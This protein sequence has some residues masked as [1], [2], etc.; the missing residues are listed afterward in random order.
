MALHVDSR[1]SRTSSRSCV[2]L[3]LLCGLFA[4]V[5]VSTALYLV[6]GMRRRR[7]KR[8]D[9]AVV[10]IVVPV[11][12]EEQTISEMLDSLLEIDYPHELLEIII[13]N[14]QSVDRTREIAKTYVGRFHCNYRVLDVDESDGPTSLAKTR[15]LMKGL[16]QAQGEFILMTDADCVIPRNW[17]RGVVSQ[18]TEDV[19]MVC[20]ITVPNLESHTRFPFTWFETLDWLLLMGVCSGFAGRDRA[21]A[22][23]GNNYAVRASTYRELG[24][25]R[26]LSF[27]HIDDIALMLAV[28][29]I[30]KQRVV[31]PAENAML[32][33]TRPL[34]SL[35]DMISQRRR[36]MAAWPHTD[37]PIK[38]VM[39]LGFVGHLSLPIWFFAGP[40][41]FALVLASLLVG[42]IAVIQAVTSRTKVHVPFWTKLSFPFFALF[43]GLGVILQVVFK[44]KIM[45][46]GRSFI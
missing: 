25:F 20:G 32:I 33:L 39:A 30:A 22:L 6:W 26:N 41:W 14:D 5:Y 2:I 46:K 35:W 19:G 13:V 11:R 23:I 3:P 17:V 18:F 38:R 36:W 44:R 34:A 29:Q 24:G 12:N 43:Y 10:S 1:R 27:Q 7:N 37:A 40:V 28:R 31:M 8:T 45:W 42:D 16:D 9:L 4:A 15:P 21:Q